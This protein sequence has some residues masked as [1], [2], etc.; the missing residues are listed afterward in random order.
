MERAEI[1][2]LLKIIG[3]SSNKHDSI[4]SALKEIL[5]SEKYSPVMCGVVT[6]KKLLKEVN[7]II[8]AFKKLNE[9]SQ[10]EI[11]D[12]IKSSDS[13]INDKKDIKSNNKTVLKEVIVDDSDDKYLIIRI[14][15]DKNKYYEKVKVLKNS[16][17][18]KRGNY[19]YS[20]FKQGTFNLL[21]NKISD[22][23]NYKY[24]NNNIYKFNNNGVVTYIYVDGRKIEIAEDNNILEELFDSSCFKYKDELFNSYYEDNN[25]DF[26]SYKIRGVYDKYLYCSKDNEDCYFDIEGNKIISSNDG[27]PF[28]K[29]LTRIGYYE[30]DKIVFYSS[31]RHII[32]Y[33][34]YD[35]KFNVSY[36]FY[37]LD[38]KKV[39]LEPCLEDTFPCLD[40]NI[41]FGKNNN[42]YQLIVI[43][44]D[45]V[46]NI[47]D[48]DFKEHNNDLLFYSPYKIYK[49][50][51]YNNYILEF[52]YDHEKN[53]RHYLIINN[54]YNK[55][56]VLWSDT[57]R[58]NYR[59]LYEVRFDLV[60]GIGDK[61]LI[62]VSYLDHYSDNLREFITVNSN[63]TISNK[64]LNP[65]NIIDSYSYLYND[66]QIASSENLLRLEEI[67]NS[68]F[69]LPAAKKNELVI[70]NKYE[71]ISKVEQYSNTKLYKE[72]ETLVKSNDDNRK[73]ARIVGVNDNGTLNVEF[74][75]GC[76]DGII[77]LKNKKFF[78]ENDNIDIACCLAGNKY[79]ISARYGN[80]SKYYVI[81][82]DFNIVLGPVDDIFGNTKDDILIIRNNNRDQLYKDYVP[83]T[84]QADEIKKLN[85]YYVRENGIV[86]KK[87][88]VYKV[89][90]GG[91]V[92][93]IDSTGDVML[94]QSK[95]SLDLINEFSNLFYENL[96]E[97]TPKVKRKNGKGE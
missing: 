38:K 63:G 75:R 35:S 33:G 86:E 48:V 15:D 39:L 52:K 11:D 56:K 25:L 46:K 19:V 42:K 40:N 37:D 2:K 14:K 85:K 26:L 53:E 31:D 4:R 96:I 71:L 64:N 29:S 84:Y 59:G 79:L 87:T 32:G 16:I 21:G 73:I 23:Y 12:A 93:I 94:E 60:T 51:D 20:I 78:S 54:I 44:D 65:S 67:K 61:A 70:S 74:E 83:F 95:E 30:K 1:L 13:I 80:G 34:V 6:D 18:Y 43:D 10:E 88:N 62:A 47:F 3:Y 69:L 91:T 89:R 9:L 17:D 49:M 57:D 8:K 7:N 76:S 5:D 68:N 97:D 41:L 82:E 66:N 45:K 58:R 72:K 28:L 22:Q 24:I 36:G 92:F 55:P 81:D 77:D 90:N 50:D 27:Y